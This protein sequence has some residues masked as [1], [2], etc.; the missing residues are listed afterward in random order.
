MLV[1]RAGV[2]EQALILDPAEI[3][4]FEQLGRE[5]HLRALRR[6]LAHELAHCADVGDRVIGKAELECSDGE[7]GHS[8]TCCEMQWKLPPPVRMWSARR[9]IA[10]RSGK[11]A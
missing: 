7:L 4:A 2:G 1:D 8:G 11:S 6:C 5:H 3:G 10:T 9:P